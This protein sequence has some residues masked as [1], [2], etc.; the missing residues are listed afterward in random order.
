[1]DQYVNYMHIKLCNTKN[2]LNV[3]LKE[4]KKTE[5]VFFECT[6]FKEYI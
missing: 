3:C 4:N 6:D 5:L 2:L 1:M